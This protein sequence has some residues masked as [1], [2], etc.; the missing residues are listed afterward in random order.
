MEMGVSR[1]V[2]KKR[3]RRERESKIERETHVAVLSCPVLSPH[4]T[5]TLQTQAII[6][7]VL[8]IIR[9]HFCPSE[10]FL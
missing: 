4:H 7:E 3:N 5:D 6:T 8:A 9:C 1:G 2:Y 10:V